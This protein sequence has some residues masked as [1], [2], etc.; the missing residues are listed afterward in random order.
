[1]AFILLSL[2]ATA[3]STATTTLVHSRRRNDLIEK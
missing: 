3:T 1:M 2:T